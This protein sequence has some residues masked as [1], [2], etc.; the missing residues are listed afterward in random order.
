VDDGSSSL[1][2]GETGGRGEG[3]E[4]GQIAMGRSYLKGLQMRG[5]TQSS[6]VRRRTWGL[7]LVVVM[8]GCVLCCRK[9]GADDS[10]T[11]GSTDPGRQR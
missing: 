3:N 7:C 8:V 5:E 4:R 9:E 11:G 2:T 6:G 10:G 1:D